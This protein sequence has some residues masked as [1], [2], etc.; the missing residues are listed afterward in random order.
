MRVRI[1]L[2]YDGAGFHG[3]ARQPDVRTVQGI[4]EGALARLAGEP[5][6][7]TGAGRTDAGVHADAQ[8]V[9]W[10]VPAAS[11]L[12]SDLDRA[13][14]ALDHLC[15]PEITVWGVRVAAP[16]FDARFSARA[17]RYRY[18]LCDAPAMAPLSRHHTWHVGSPAL[19]VAAMHRGGQALV[20]EH[21][22]SSFCRRA[23]DRSLV[24]RVDRVAV[25]RPSPGLATVEVDGAAFCHQM[26]RS[27]VG[28]LVAVGRGRRRPEEV[29][30][31]LAARDRA[32]AAAVAP[33]HGL[34]LTGVDY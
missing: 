17:R 8:V 3:F 22:F 11:R 28:H 9:S 24:R 25:A 13:R 27:M 31:V 12:L 14:A 26:V 15:G 21:D 34:T 16:D 2:A 4:L 20:G 23:G 29:A 18:R 1:D 5:V 19:D 7:T 30:A 6:V 32:A 10:D 33:P